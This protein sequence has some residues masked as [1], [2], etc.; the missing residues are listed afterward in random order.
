MV[1]NTFPKNFIIIFLFI[2]RK[3]HWIYIFISAKLKLVTD[4]LHKYIANSKIVLVNLCL[5]WNHNIK[6]FYL[7]AVIK[8]ID[9]KTWGIA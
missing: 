3:K 6:L 4:T 5:I 8:G 1:A 7:S 2:G 9:L